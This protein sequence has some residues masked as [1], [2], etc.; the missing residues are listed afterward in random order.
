MEGATQRGPSV[1]E[2]RGILFLEESAGF[3]LPELGA[4]SLDARGTQP[5][6]AVC[7]FSDLERRQR[8]RAE[9]ERR[10]GLTLVQ[11]KAGWL[12][13]AAGWPVLLSLL[14]AVISASR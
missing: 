13:S 7:G 10:E 3:W 6:Q 9:R 4:A 11:C 12:Y 14:A 8:A 2:K 1:S 5:A